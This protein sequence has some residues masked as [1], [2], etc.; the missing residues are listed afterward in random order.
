MQPLT[1][2]SIHFEHTLR[3][4]GI[5]VLIITLGWYVQYQ[6]RNLIN[7]PSLTLS[8][9]PT[10]IQHEQSVT[11]T[12]VAKNIVSISLNGK[13]I[14]TDEHG[15]FSDTLILENGYT[16]MTLEAKDRYGRATSLSRTFVYVPQT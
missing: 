15:V 11:L 2:S 5:V 7:G 4:V 3:N 1:P 13:P 9:T 12:G 6:A 16:I 8:E 10:V 14:F